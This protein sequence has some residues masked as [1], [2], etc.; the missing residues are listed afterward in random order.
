MSAPASLDAAEA[1]TDSDLR[2]TITPL[3]FA[4]RGLP[5]E[6]AKPGPRALK[7]VVITDALH[8]TR[9]REVLGLEID[10]V[11]SGAFWVEFLRSLRSSRLQG[12]R[13]CVS[14]DPRGYWRS[15]GCSPAAGSAAPD[16]S[17]GTSPGSPSA[18]PPRRTR[19]P[20]TPSPAGPVQAALD[21]SGR[22]NREIGR[23]TDVVGIP[24]DAAVIRAPALCS[25]SRT[26]V[27]KER[28]GRRGG[29]S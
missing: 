9:V 14:E 18:R 25:S 3:T 27:M 11:E 24:D 13:R 10:E 19:L 16:V 23:R 29:L 26:T 6:G 8:E 28:P 22:V 1:R 2:T 12:V 17:A 21:Q 4:R 7:A 5:S 20:S 15:P